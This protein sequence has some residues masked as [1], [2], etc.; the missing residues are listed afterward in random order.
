MANYLFFIPSPRNRYSTERLR[1]VYADLLH[2]IDLDDKMSE[3]DRLFHKKATRFSYR[4][5]SLIPLNCTN[6]NSKEN[7]GEN[8]IRDEESRDAP[9]SEQYFAHAS[10]DDNNV[11]NHNNNNSSS[12]SSSNNHTVHNVDLATA[13]R[14]CSATKSPDKEGDN[15]GAVAIRNDSSV[16]GIQQAKALESRVVMLI[17]AIGDIVVNG[18]N[19]EN[20][21]CRMLNRQRSLSSLSYHNIKMDPVFEY[22][23]EKS[24]LSL[25]VDIAKEVRQGI[26]THSMKPCNAS[27]STSVHGVVWSATVKAQVYK[28]VSSIIANVRDQSVL[29]YFLSNNHINQ[30]IQCMQPLQQW[31]EPAIVKLLPVYVDLLKNLTL[32]L[33]DDPHLFPFLTLESDVANNDNDIEPSAATTDIQFPLFSAALETACN[34]FAQSDPQIYA[35]CL[36]IIINLMHIPNVSIQN[37]ISQSS[38]SQRI[39]ADHL[40]QRLHNRY[41]RI[42]NLTRGPVVDSARNKTIACQL[43][44]L[45]D[46]MGIVHEIFCSGVRGMDV[47]LCESLLQRVVS[48]LLMNLSQISRNR[49]FLKVGL[50][51][52]DV[53]PESEASAQVSTVFFS[54]MFSNLR[55]MPF[56]R[57][58]GVSLFHPL[59]TPLW[60][61]FRQQNKDVDFQQEYLLMPALSD[62]VNEE[63]SRDTCNNI[64]RQDLLKTL[65]GEYGEWRAAAAACLLQSVLIVNTSDTDT[66]VLA[67]LKII[68]DNKSTSLEHSIA[69]FLTR[70]H[71]PSAVALKS[72]EVMGYLALLVLYH[73]L[74]NIIKDKRG[75]DTK[76]CVDNMLSKSVVWNALVNACDLFCKKTIEI[77]NESFLDLTEAAIRNRYTGRYNDSG[78]AVFS[79]LL[80]RHGCVTNVLDADLLVRQ[81]R[82]ASATDVETTRFYINIS[83]FF[84]SLCKVVDQ[85]CYNAEIEAT[86]SLVSATKGFQNINLHLVDEA[87]ELIKIIGGLSSDK[88]EIGSR[89]DLNGRV[90]FRFQSTFENFEALNSSA[91]NINTSKQFEGIPK[92]KGGVTHST[93]RHL[94][95]ILDPTD[96]FI[97]K[98]LDK[99][100]DEN[101]GTIQC[102]ISIRSIIG[103][104][105]DGRWLHIALKNQDIHHLTKNGNMALQFES[106]GTCLVVKQYLDRSREVLRQNL[107][108]KIGDLFSRP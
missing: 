90:F 86:K 45:K 87:D 49:P 88:P 70:S 63:E 15:G 66:D 31:T 83:L 25:F 97:V 38:N 4:F 6:D 96:I 104:A 58:L 75:N 10:H 32:R 102:E 2:H 95:L 16:C 13:F 37:W 42:I 59:S 85:L 54:Y 14:I 5:R 27:A 23:F 91:F 22:F 81:C 99:N 71:K 3:E 100:I 26:N 34:Y 8:E 57:M 46:E 7:H 73:N 18:G 47:C 51:D 76:N 21:N 79:C 84:R 20:N 61:T 101:R 74:I 93:A 107:L 39:L 82:G 56:V 52:A 55:Y 40:C 89:L 53:I 50:I 108:T 103:A 77:R 24:I 9:D 43:I 94:L 78:L 65:A 28:T 29:Y 33:A 72:L 11:Y 68:S 30:L 41:N 67:M 69:T 35:T 48:V 17:A 64:H 98:P 19:G 106:N 44:S 62:V 1:V 80:Y 12:G 60:S 36:S 105:C 92:V